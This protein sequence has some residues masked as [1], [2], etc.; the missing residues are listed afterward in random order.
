MTYV[1][2]L[3][4]TLAALGL[5]YA[6][7]RH[8]AEAATILIVAL[9]LVVSVPHNTPHWY[10]SLRAY[11]RLDASSAVAVAPPV[12]T[13]ERNLSLARRALASIAP[14]ETYAVVLAHRRPRRTAAARRERARLTYLDSWF[15]YWLAPRIRVDPSDA[16]WLIL[17]DAAERPPPRSALETYRIGKDLLVRRR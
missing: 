11:Y 16:Q 2:A 9:P 8:R 17:L 10:Q 6:R 5:A 1:S 4:L 13:A 12:I 3:L 7:R 15:Q 14:D